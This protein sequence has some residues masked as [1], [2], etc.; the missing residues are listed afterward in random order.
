[1]I[2]ACAADHEQRDRRHTLTASLHDRTRRSCLIHSRRLYRVGKTTRMSAM[3]AETARAFWIAAPGRGEIR[4]EPLPPPSADDVVV[5]AIYSGISRGTEALVFDGR[6]P[7]SE[8]ERMRAPFQA[9]DFPGAGEIWLCQR[10]PRRAR[11]AAS[12]GAAACSCCIRIR[13]ATSCRPTPVHVLPRR[14]SAGARGAGR[15]SRDGDQRRVGRR[16]QLGDRVPVI[17]GGTVGCLVAW[18]AGRIPGCDVELVDINPRA[19]ALARAL[20]VAFALP[21]GARPRRRRRHSR[22]RFAGG[23]RARACASP[24][25]KRRSSS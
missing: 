16:P 9:G 4:T 21:D 14:C 13:R 11:S 19:V 18:L 10:R 17:G 20:G 15:E 25:S 6:V 8:Y 24:A 7:P 5:R 2:G 23:P 3:P 1:M 22:Q 12:C